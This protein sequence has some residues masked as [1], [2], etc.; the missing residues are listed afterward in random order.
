MRRSCA[1]QATGENRSRILLNPDSCSNALDAFRLFFAVCVVAIHTHASDGLS[2]VLSFWLTQGVF[3]LAVPFFFVTSGFLLGRKLCGQEQ[4]RQRQDKLD[5]WR[6]GWKHDGGER[7]QEIVTVLRRYT[8]RLFIPLLIVE[9]ANATLELITRRLRYG[10]SLRYL[11][12]HFARHILFYPYGAMWFIQACIIG[13]WLL[14]PFLKRKKTNSA[15][16]VGLLLYGWALLCN[17]Y[18]F[19]AQAVGLDRVVNSY[20]NLFISARNGVFVGFF[21]L[22][23]GIKA[24]EL[25]SADAD[26]SRLRQYPDGRC[27]Y[28]SRKRQ[29]TIWD[30]RRLILACVTLLYVAEIYLTRNCAYLDDRALYLAHILLLPLLLLCI[31][32]VRLSISDDVSIRMRK[33][34]AW[35][36]FSHRF[37]YGLGGFLCVLKFG[38]EWRGAGAFTL[39]LAV[40]TVSFV[41]A[42]C[43]RRA[44]V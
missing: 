37:I 35:L 3:R 14:Y 42:V 25:Y 41:P 7:K 11:A 9:G 13:A 44:F 39:V 5:Q 36:Y 10:K 33:V 30:C 12:E 4:D 1:K 8:L 27:Q 2:R 24:W 15:L 21:F 43:L 17:N 22:A 18:Y 40:S 23:L 31:V 19:L 29:H 28:Q 32:D 34:S 6:K 38:T 20:M 16:L 26:I